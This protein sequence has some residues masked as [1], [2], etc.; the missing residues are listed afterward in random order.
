MGFKVK[1]STRKATKAA[2]QKAR[3]QSAARKPTDLAV[4]FPEKHVIS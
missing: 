4:I 1:E 3:C 2:N